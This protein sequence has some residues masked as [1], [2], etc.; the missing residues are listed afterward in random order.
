MLRRLKKFAFVTFLLALTPV[1]G[2]S[3]QYRIDPITVQPS[4]FI[5]RLKELRAKEANSTDLVEKANAL[6]NA[7]GIGYNISFDA[8]TCQKLR[9]AKEKMADKT[10]P[11]KVGATL[12]SVDAEGAALTLPSPD[13]RSEECGGC[14]IELPLLQLT[15][16]DFIAVIRGRNLKFHLPSNFLAEQIVMF[17]PK[18]PTV[19]TKRWSTPFRGTPVGVSHDSS[20]VYLA[21]P[22][23]ELS[24]LTLAVFT[25]GVFQIAS[26][27]EAEEGG[28]GKVS[29][30][31][32][33]GNINDRRIRF[34]RWGNTYL[35]GYRQPCPR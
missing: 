14:S 10:A 30:P 12:K 26:L 22:D 5:A 33:A 13:I 4:G 15:Q 2:F 7:E 11:L 32:A 16:N 8:G 19:I 1:T 28:R 25:E 31:P 21:F 23:P 3:Q 35:L 24:D 20:V 6:L 27:K 18:D 9:E 29:T 17:D 34:D